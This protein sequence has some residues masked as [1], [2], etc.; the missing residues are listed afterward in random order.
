MFNVKKSV[1]QWGYFLVVMMI[2]VFGNG[3][4]ENVNEVQKTGVVSSKANPINPG[5]ARLFDENFFL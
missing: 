5:I 2:S 4:P 3:D 1:K